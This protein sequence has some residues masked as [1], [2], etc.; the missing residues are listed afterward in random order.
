MGNCEESLA[1]GAAD[2]GCG[3]DQ[4]SSCDLLSGQ[5]FSY[6]SALI[7]D[8]MRHWMAKL[9]RRLE[10]TLQRCAAGSHSWRGSTDKPLSVRLAGRI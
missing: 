7:D 9:P 5:W 10:F 6:A 2:C 8:G 3:F 4:G 1:E